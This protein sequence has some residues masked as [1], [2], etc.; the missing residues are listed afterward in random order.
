MP[1]KVEKGMIFRVSARK[2]T[3]ELQY[4]RKA[5]MEQYK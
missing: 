4:K 2:K 3:N 5:Y 1:L